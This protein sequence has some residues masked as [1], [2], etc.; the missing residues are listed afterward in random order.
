MQKKK[1]QKRK[2]S[3]GVRFL[4]DTDFSKLGQ[5]QFDGFSLASER[6]FDLVIRTSRLQN[7]D[8]C[9]HIINLFKKSLYDVNY[10]GNVKINLRESFVKVDIDQPEP[11]K[12]GVYI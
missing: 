3:G 8:F 10:V 9:L 1:E 6:R 12:E 4:V 11:M 5:F 7:E 2:P